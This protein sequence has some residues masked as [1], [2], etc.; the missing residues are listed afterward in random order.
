MERPGKLY[1]LGGL[2][3][4][5]CGLQ[6]ALLVGKWPMLLGWAAA[7]LGGGRAY[8]AL[9]V[10]GSRMELLAPS[11]LTHPQCPDFL[12]AGT[13]LAGSDLREEDGAQGHLGEAGLSRQGWE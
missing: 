4:F 1:G 12:G 10:F 8:Q 11:P 3:A 2:Q 7:E 9:W 6:R 13:E 5:L